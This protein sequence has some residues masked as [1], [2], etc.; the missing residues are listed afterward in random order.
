MSMVL[1]GI[2]AGGLVRATVT[3]LGIVVANI[4]VNAYLERR[5]TLNGKYSGEP[6]PFFGED[7]Y[8]YRITTFEPWGHFRSNCRSYLLGGL[9]FIALLWIVALLIFACLVNYYLYL[10]FHHIPF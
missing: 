2:L 8:Y 7:L 3:A 6:E 10:A 1:L 9:R 5:D 4:L